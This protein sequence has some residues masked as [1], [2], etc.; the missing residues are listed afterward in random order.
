MQDPAASIHIDGF[1]TKVSEL[2]NAGLAQGSPLSPI[3]FTLLNSGVVNQEVDTR[4][5]TS[6]SIDDYSRWRVR[7]SAEE[8]LRKI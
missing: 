7:E 1:S 8:N 2:Q 5:G 6:A 4:G 3:L